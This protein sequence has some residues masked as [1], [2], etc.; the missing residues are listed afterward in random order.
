MEVERLLFVSAERVVGACADGGGRRG[1]CTGARAACSCCAT[2]AAAIAVVLVALTVVLHVGH[3]GS[4]GCLGAALAPAAMAW[5]GN[6]TATPADALRAAFPP[7]TVFRVA[8]DVE[9]SGPA[10]IVVSAA[11]LAA[12]D[13]GGSG[14]CAADTAAR[15]ARTP[16]NTSWVW[17][18]GA[19]SWNVSAAGGSGRGGN[20]TAVSGR[21]SIVQRLMRA[22]PPTLTQGALRDPSLDPLSSQFAPDYL[23]GSALQPLTMGQAARTAAAYPVVNITLPYACAPLTVGAANAFSSVPLIIAV[24]G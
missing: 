11:R 19:H 2:A 18:W 17:A 9:A 22:A 8:I 21:A 5:V 20:A 6:T 3:V 1:A 12:C 7:G 16:F 15:L 23:L 13:P 14:V 4:A 24:L 10:A